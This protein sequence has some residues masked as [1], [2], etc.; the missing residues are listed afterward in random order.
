MGKYG[1]N[2]QATLKKLKKLEI[3]NIFP[4]HGPILTKNIEHYFSLYDTWSKYIPEEEGVVIVYSTIYG[5]TKSAIEKLAEKLN[6]LGVKYTIYDIAKKHWTNIISETYKYNT[7]VLASIM[8]DDDISPSMKEFI[9]ILSSFEY[10]NRKVGFI[11]NGSWNPKSNIIMK[12]MLAS[13]KNLEFFENSV[14][15]RVSLNEKSISQINDLASEIAG[16][17]K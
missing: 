13:C 5:H 4:G 9:E 12:S 16:I 11:E 8:I 3:N 2:V 1:R 6:S 15:V 7:L 17:K 14:S 10:Q